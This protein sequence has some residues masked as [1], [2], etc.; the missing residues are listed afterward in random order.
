MQALNHKPGARSEASRRSHSA[1]PAFKPF[2]QEPFQR[3][4]STRFSKACL[5]EVLSVQFEEGR[6]SFGGRRAS[7][8]LLTMRRRA[9]SSCRSVSSCRPPLDKA[10]A[11]QACRAIVHH[12]A[13]Y[14][15]P[16]PAFEPT[17]NSGPLRAGK[18]CFAQSALPARSVP[19]L[20]AAQRTR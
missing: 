18:A 1:V 4:G 13:G 16:N 10:G 12:S 5:A 6:P 17:A 8:K 20:A 11:Y 3:S 9:I 7:G 15:L 14:R 19:P 2:A